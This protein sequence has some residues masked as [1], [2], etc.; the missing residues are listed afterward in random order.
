M[1][2][3]DQI[4]KTEAK[5]Y[6]KRKSKIKCAYIKQKSNAK[7]RG[8]AFLLTYGEWLGVWLLSGRMHQRGNFVCVVKVT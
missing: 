2:L 8:I 1:P 7:R 3:V 5:K 4:E 6:I